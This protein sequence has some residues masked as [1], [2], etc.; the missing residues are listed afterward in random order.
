MSNS[1]I[2]QIVEALLENDSFKS[3]IIGC[4][5][6]GAMSFELIY[7]IFVFILDFFEPRVKKYVQKVWLT[8]RR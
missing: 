6:I 1:E 8:W 7:S 2:L 4:G 5:V 3:V